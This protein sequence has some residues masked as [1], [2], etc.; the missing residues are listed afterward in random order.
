MG[1]QRPLERVGHVRLHLDGHR[2]LLGAQLA[3]DGNDV[4]DDRPAAHVVQADVGF[5]IVIYCFVPNRAR[6]FSRKRR[7]PAAPRRATRGPA[8]TTFPTRGSGAPARRRLIVN[9]RP[10]RRAR[11]LRVPSRGA[12]TRRRR[13]RASTAR[14]Q[15]RAAPVDLAGA[16]FHQIAQIVQLRELCVAC[17]CAR[18]P[19]GAS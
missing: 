2:A 11:P 4:F 9:Q 8:P 17:S 7:G 18:T 6:I 10:R 1:L 12:T 19:R 3:E 14:R 5:R 13:A 16:Q 15:R